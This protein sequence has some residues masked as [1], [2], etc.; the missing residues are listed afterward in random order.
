MYHQ[1]YSC[2]HCSFASSKQHVSTIQ[3][4]KQHDFYE[5]ACE[6]SKAKRCT[7]CPSIL[8]SYLYRKTRIQN[9]LFFWKWFFRLLHMCLHADWQI[10]QKIQIK[11]SLL[12]IELF[13]SKCQHSQYDRYRRIGMNPIYP[14]NPLPFPL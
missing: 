6:N 1:H 8:N 14:Q 7:Q 10:L 5:K 4:K 3:K 9:S 13:T 11:L 12:P 2:L